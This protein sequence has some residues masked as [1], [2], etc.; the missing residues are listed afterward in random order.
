MRRA[1]WIQ[2][3]R[4][5]APIVA[6]C[7]FSVCICASFSSKA[8]ASDQVDLLSQPIRAVS[9]K[10]ETIAFALDVLTSEYRIP[11][12]IELTDEKLSPRR[13]I[14]LDLSHT[15]VKG[16]LDSV[17]EKDPEYT[18]KLE[19]G[20]IHV[21]PVTNRDTLIAGLLDTKISH[22][23]IG[24]T[25]SRYRIHSDILDLPEIK[26]KLIVAGVEP[27]TFAAFGSTF[28]LQKGVGFEQSD[29]TLRELLD[30]LAQQTE[31]NRWVIRR[32]GDNN[33]FITITS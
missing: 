4:K 14:D 2:L 24:E 33:E 1:E 16:L 8:Q 29:L 3:N 18:W 31:I 10:G 26:T 20:V 27:M 21:W 22:F 7:L 6:V 13:K 15:T 19:G 23:S 25:A 28:R 30:K 5:R 17:I 12:G 32:W 11:I 9:I